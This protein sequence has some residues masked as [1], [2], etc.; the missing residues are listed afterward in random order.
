MKILRKSDDK[1][2]FVIRFNKNELQVVDFI[3]K[4]DKDFN[5]NFD[6]SVTS[7]PNEYSIIQKAIFNSEDCIHYFNHCFASDV[8]DGLLRTEK[9][10]KIRYAI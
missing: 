1:I 8:I 6:I 4:N 5:D 9:I 3:I 2:S 10:K 7:I